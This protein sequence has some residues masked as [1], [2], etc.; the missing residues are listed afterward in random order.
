MFITGVGTINDFRA[1][2]ALCVSISVICHGGEI[3]SCVVCPPAPLSSCQP[4][5]RYTSC[6]GLLQKKIKSYLSVRSHQRQAIIVKTQP[7]YVGPCLGIMLRLPDTCS[8]P[9]TASGH[10]SPVCVSDDSCQCRSSGG[11]DH[12]NPLW[13]HLT[14]CWE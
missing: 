7:L 8:A 9:A 13:S 10:K 14:I 11:R 2:L 4:L 5:S 12:S 6:A 1:W 3:S